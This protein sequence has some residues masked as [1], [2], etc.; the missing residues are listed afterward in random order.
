MAV[1]FEQIDAEIS[2]QPS[3]APQ[4]QPARTNDPA[5]LANQIR[6]EIALMESRY[7]RLI[8]D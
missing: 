3:P 4:A 6:R 7:R 2:D 1:M 5:E 8:A